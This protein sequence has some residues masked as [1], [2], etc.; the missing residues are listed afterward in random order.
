MEQ[1]LLT[2][3]PFTASE[4]IPTTPGARNAARV[5]RRVG[6]TASRGGDATGSGAD[7]RIMRY[8]YKAD[9][10]GPTA[11]KKS[12]RTTAERL[13]VDTACCAETGAK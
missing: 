1:M 13:L 8:G 6:S 2:S 3:S 9:W 12:A 11:I 7:A 10:F 5:V 4:R